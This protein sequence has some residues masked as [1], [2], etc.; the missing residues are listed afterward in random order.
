MVV[1]LSLSCYRRTYSSKHLSSSVEVAPT[2]YTIIDLRS[3][4]LI[5]VIILHYSAIVVSCAS[6][7]VAPTN[8]TIIDFWS[9]CRGGYFVDMIQ[10]LALLRSGEVGGTKVRLDRLQVSHTSVLISLDWFPC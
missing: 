9:T 7:E 3:L 1:P 5:I 8:Y 6:V 2:N 4:G 10:F